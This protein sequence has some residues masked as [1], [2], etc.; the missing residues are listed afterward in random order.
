MIKHTSTK[1]MPYVYIG[2][3]SITGEVYIGYREKN[4]KLNRPSDIDLLMYRTSSKVVRPKFDEFNWQ[5]IAEF[6]S[7][8]DAYAFEQ[9]LIHEHWGDPLLVN[10][11]CHYGKKTV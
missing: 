10:Q 8:N 4:V 3:H 7:G 1:P 6:M 9:Q 2:T 11:S 5:V